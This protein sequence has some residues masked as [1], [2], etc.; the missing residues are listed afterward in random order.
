GVKKIIASCPHCFHTLGKE[1]ADYGGDQLEVLHHSEV[2]AKLQDDGKLPNRIKNERDITY[3]DPCYLGRI[4]GILEEPRSVI[5][6]VDVEAERSGQD[7]FCCGAGGAQMWLEEDADK[8]VN[9]IRAK[10]LAAT[11]CDTVAVGCP[12]CSVMIGDGLKS[13]GK[14]M[15]VLDIAELLW[16]QIKA[17]DEE[18]NAASEEE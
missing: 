18:I 1:Y 11:G 12:F 3:H 6:G 5:G 13:I 14:E 2:I 10:D 17:K 16:E 7:S 9:E 8:R 15:E 4:G